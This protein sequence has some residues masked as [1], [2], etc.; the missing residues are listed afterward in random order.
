MNYLEKKYLMYWAGMKTWR[1]LIFII[2]IFLSPVARPA[3]VNESFVS[4]TNLDSAGGMV[5]NLSLGELHPPLEVLNWSDGVVQ[6]TSYSVGDGSH[7]V[8]APS[9]YA[10][11]DSNG[12]IS[13]GVIEINTDAYPNLEF[14]SFNLA[15]GYT[16]R[17][18]GLSPLVIRVQDS[19]LIDGTID[20]SGDDGA[21]GVASTGVQIAG[22][23]G[24]CGGGSGGASVLPGFA[25]NA[26]N[27]GVAGGPSVSGGDGG[28]I[29]LAT[30]GQGGGGGGAYIKPFALGAF[31]PDPT[32]GDDSLGGAAGSAGSI[33]RD[34]GFILEINGAGSGGGGGS[35]FDDPGDVP[36]HSSGASGG[37]GG[38]S[39]QIY[40]VGDITVSA[41]GSI[42][43]SGGDGGSVAGGLKGGGGGA[44]GGGSILIFSGGDIVFDGAVL[45]EAGIGGVTAGGDGGVG[46]WG[47][48]FIVEKDGLAAGSIY[49]DPETQLNSPGNVRYETGV[50]YTVTS[51]AIDLK[52]TQPTILNLPM[53]VVNLG[54]S[55][56]TYNLAFNNSNSLSLLSGFNLSSS[57]LN[58]P[59]QRFF[60][61]QI[62]VDNLDA[63]NPIRIQDLSVTYSGFE[64]NEFNY[65]TGCG[66]IDTK[67][68]LSSVAPKNI[69]FFIL[70]ISL[71]LWLRSRKF[72][73][74]HSIPR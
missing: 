74:Y 26:T 25:P 58:L 59:M 5:W 36:S 21:S 61:F 31:K 68:P 62:Q 12:V 56:L 49:E 8:F 10:I 44:G 34:D 42:L 33:F 67:S 22:G 48:T 52:N 2:A 17:P 46:A 70:P 18:T 1:S 24:R 4:R 13:G 6:T 73:V 14:V 11:F 39:I 57:Y 15:S 72:A 43:A 27:K 28:P 32:S 9:R 35:A 63:L 55:T 65:T 69:L 30:G 60:R 20:C 71:V 50:T 45:A 53:T 54:G 19:V 16:L 38:G 23:I 47:R 3:T 51:K 29:R 64:Q 66:A 37:A 7:G 41:T 40:S